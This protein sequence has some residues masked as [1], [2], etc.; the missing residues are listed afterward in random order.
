MFANYAGRISDLPAEVTPGNAPLDGFPT[1]RILIS[2]YDD[3]RPSGELFAA[4]LAE[5]G[6]P[7]EAQL[8]AGMLHGHLNRTPAL[9]E[10]SRSL[11]F[12]ATGIR[13]T[14]ATPSH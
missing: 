14:P 9:P 13:N 1:T 6:V 7:V 2:E 10:V 4:Q 5:A 11:D 12:L 3:F 8:A